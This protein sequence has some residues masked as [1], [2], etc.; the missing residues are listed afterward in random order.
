VA[1]LSYVLD[2]AVSQD[3]Q[4]RHNIWTCVTD[5]LDN[6]PL[7]MH[8]L[9]KALGVRDIPTHK[10]S[11]AAKLGFRSKQTKD[12]DLAWR[13]D[14]LREGLIDKLLELRA[15]SNAL[16]HQAEANDVAPEKILPVL[17]KNGPIQLNHLL[18]NYSRGSQG[19]D[20]LGLLDATIGQ[21]LDF[22]DRVQVVGNAQYKL[23]SDA[24][25]IVRMAKRRTGDWSTRTAVGGG[26]LSAGAGMGVLALSLTGI[27]AGTAVSVLSSGAALVPL[28]A[29]I[30]VR[31]AAPRIN[32]SRYQRKLENDQV[33]I[34]RSDKF[35]SKSY[36]LPRILRATQLQQALERS[37]YDPAPRYPKKVIAKAFE[38]I[39]QR[40]EYLTDLTKPLST[41]DQERLT[42]TQ[43]AAYQARM[44]LSPQELD[45]SLAQQCG[46][47]VP[48]LVE[49]EYM[50]ISTK[51]K[52]MFDN[53]FA[54]A[55]TAD[56]DGDPQ[57]LATAEALADKLILN[58]RTI[59]QAKL[60]G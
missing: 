27:V 31:I 32:R 58:E 44:A 42:A 40:A 56:A 9:A 52:A 35:L 53:A 15:V 57:I 36:E 33:N 14:N 47:H 4:D 50:E 21:T 49:Q 29:G 13:N 46:G 37:V 18:L 55:E 38:I 17:C 23:S 2:T 12:A 60:E 59:L 43:R 26:Y 34:P 7:V 3:P 51:S 22:Q 45:Q 5:I 6:D 8:R 25:L 16:M 41:K 48:I 24:R 20:V 54:S 30:G 28:V 1:Q 19:P 11:N 10:A 39:E